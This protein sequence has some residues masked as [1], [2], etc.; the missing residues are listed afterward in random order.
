MRQGV[1]TLTNKEIETNG[2]KLRIAI[3][4]LGFLFILTYQQFVKN[5]N[6]L[7]TY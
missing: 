6:C 3:L 2:V 1:K 7:F 5:V 4:L